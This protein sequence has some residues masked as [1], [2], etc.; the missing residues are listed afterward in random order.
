[1]QTSA[2]TLPLKCSIQSAVSKRKK[3]KGQRASASPVQSRRQP[4]RA[5]NSR[6]SNC[7]MIVSRPGPLAFLEAGVAPLLWRC[8][9]SSIQCGGAREALL[10]NLGGAAPCMRSPYCLIEKYGLVYQRRCSFPHVLLISVLR[11]GEGWRR[12]GTGY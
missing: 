3:E 7:S 6:N 11:A 4:R 12:A 1:M 2:I 5:M 10:S 9:T 8:G